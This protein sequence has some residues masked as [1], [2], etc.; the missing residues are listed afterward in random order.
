MKSL[1]FYGVSPLHGGVV[2]KDRL[3]CTATKVCNSYSMAVLDPVLYS[4]P[5]TSALRLEKTSSR[6][7]SLFESSSS[8]DKF[9]ISCMSKEKI[10]FSGVG[11][12]KENI[13]I[14]YIYILSAYYRRL[15]LA[16]LSSFNL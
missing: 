9:R 13:L 10:G 5:G 12:W 7:S 4:L 8:Y 16:Y 3:L 14:D 6:L 2:A 1:A 15:Y 11:V